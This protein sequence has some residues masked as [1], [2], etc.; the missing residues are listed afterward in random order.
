MHRIL[1]VSAAVLVLGLAP[2]PGSAASLAQRPVTAANPSITLVDGWWEQEHHE[3]DAPNRYWQLQQ[4][5]R[6]RYDRLQA[7]QRR[8]DEQRRKFDQDDRRALQEQHGIL[9]FQLTIH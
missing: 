2:Q 9:G 4:E 1:F 6:Q 7:E 3:Q 5:Q 8:R